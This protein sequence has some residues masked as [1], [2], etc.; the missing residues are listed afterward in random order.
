MSYIHIDRCKYTHRY[1]ARIPEKRGQRVDMRNNRRRFDKNRWKL[2]IYN[3]K[4]RGSEEAL[5]KS[6][7]SKSVIK[8]KILS[9]AKG[10]QT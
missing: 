2:Q 1:L 9:A 5:S 10:K 8:E 3:W 7:S 4:Q 6:S